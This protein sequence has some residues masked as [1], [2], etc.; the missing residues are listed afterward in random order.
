MI[1]SKGH[2]W[3]VHQPSLDA[4]R[5]VIAHIIQTIF[6]RKDLNQDQK[7]QLVQHLQGLNHADMAQDVQK[8]Q[9]VDA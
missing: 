6:E 4:V 1:D 2:K 5:S 7:M 9:Q 8:I 3:N